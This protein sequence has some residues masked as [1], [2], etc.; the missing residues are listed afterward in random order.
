[1]KVEEAQK[2]ETEGA[3]THLR[4]PPSDEEDD[5]G[6]KVNVEWPPVDFNELDPV[7]LPFGP[8]TLEKRVEL[9]NQVS[10]Q[11]ENE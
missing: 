1:M 2:D 10:K 11:L 9:A 8:R 6:G 5:E 7:A 3:E 4:P